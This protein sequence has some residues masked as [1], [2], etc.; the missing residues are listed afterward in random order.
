MDGSAAFALAEFDRMTSL[1]G[2]GVGKAKER[3]GIE[4]MVFCAIAELEDYGLPSAMQQ[5]VEKS[6][7]DLAVPILGYTDFEWSQHGLLVD[8]KTLHA[9]PSK[10]R[11]SHARQGAFYVAASKGNHEARITYVT[12]KKSATYRVDEPKRHVEALR[13]IAMS[14]QR[15]VALS[16][17]P[18]ELAGLIGVDFDSFYWSDPA[19]RQ[20]GFEVFGY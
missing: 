10:I 19:T 12:P 7:E 20:A 16:T 13:L 11:T 2:D 14:I 17:D 9:L 8:L 6:F 4:A 5:K 18:L 3:A 15:F 1:M